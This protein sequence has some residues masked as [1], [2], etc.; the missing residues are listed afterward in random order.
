MRRQSAP[1]NTTP[2]PLARL[3]ECPHRDAHLRSAARHCHSP[4]T[5][6]SFMSRLERIRTLPVGYGGNRA[7]LFA[8]LQPPLL[9]VIQKENRAVNQ[10]WKSQPG[11]NQQVKPHAM[12]RLCYRLGRLGLESCQKIGRKRLRPLPA[13]S[14]RRTDNGPAPWSCVPPQRAETVTSSSHGRRTAIFSLNSMQVLRTSAV[15]SVQF[16]I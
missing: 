1:R 3:E 12:P 6:P 11:C 16:S 14:A 9:H 15:I 10:G 13:K 5:R 2:S 8:G 4:I 7:G